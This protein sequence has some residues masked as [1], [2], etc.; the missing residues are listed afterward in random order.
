PVPVSGGHAFTAVSDGLGY[1]FC[2]VR[3]DLRTMCWG[4]NEYGELG[5]GNLTDRNVPTLLPEL[6]GVSRK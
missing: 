5:T 3:N 6:S 2:A 4:W 1:H